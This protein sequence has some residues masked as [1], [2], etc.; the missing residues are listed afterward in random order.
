MA[1][2]F[3]FCGILLLAFGLWGGRY[4]VRA[5]STAIET[6][7]TVA[8]IAE[9][10]D[11]VDADLAGRLVRVSI[12]EASLYRIGEKIPVYYDPADPERV[13]HGNKVSI[14]I[15]RFVFRAFVVMGAATAGLA[16]LALF[17]S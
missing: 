7:A 4:A 6:T 10:D 1:W 16:A 12:H 17:R 14:G 2:F 8:A 15:A 13:S 11:W 5:R 3:L 9:T